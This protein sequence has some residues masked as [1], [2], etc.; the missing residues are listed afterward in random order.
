MFTICIWITLVCCSF[1]GVFT[2]FM[3]ELET[4]RVDSNVIASVFDKL[5]TILTSCFD[6]PVPFFTMRTFLI[7]RISLTARKSHVATDFY[8]L[9]SCTLYWWNSC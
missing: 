2:N 1:F 3:N 7:S 5:L 8:V 6:W 4:T 9:F